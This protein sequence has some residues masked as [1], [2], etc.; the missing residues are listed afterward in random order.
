MRFVSVV[1][2]LGKSKMEATVEDAAGHRR[3]IEFSWFGKVASDV[4]PDHWIEAIQG[5]VDFQRADEV[6]AESGR[7]LPF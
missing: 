1:L 5:E 6:A 2:Y 4:P 3:R 7:K